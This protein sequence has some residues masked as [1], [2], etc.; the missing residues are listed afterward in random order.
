[1]GGR[2]RCWKDPEESGPPFFLSQ[3]P[4][5]RSCVL[6]LD[7]DC[8]CSSSWLM[9]AMLAMLA[10]LRFA[11]LNV[12]YSNGISRTSSKLLLIPCRE[13]GTVRSRYRPESARTPKIQQS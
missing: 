2:G 3:G 1:M 5:T 8:N 7:C 13:I 6:L 9:L 11:A 4:G 12:M 10:A